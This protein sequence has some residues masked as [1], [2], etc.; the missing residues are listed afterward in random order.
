MSA[1]EAVLLHVA[2]LTVVHQGY[3]GVRTATFSSWDPQQKEIQLA[4]LQVFSENRTPVN[5]ES[6]TWKINFKWIWAID[7]PLQVHRACGAHKGAEE[8]I[9][10]SFHIGL[11][12]V[13]NMACPFKTQIS[14]TKLY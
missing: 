3:P 14:V 12:A 1:R 10:G 7:T 2:G 6:H 9:G 8:R 4:C 5:Q 11:T 13:V